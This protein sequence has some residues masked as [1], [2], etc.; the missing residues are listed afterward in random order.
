M[1]VV[2][3]SRKQEILVYHL[4]LCLKNIICLSVYL[5][6]LIL[7]NIF[8]LAL[9]HQCRTECRF[10]KL[11]DRELHRIDGSP[12][13]PLWSSVSWKILP[14][15]CFI[16][17]KLEHRGLGLK[18]NKRGQ[19]CTAQTAYFDRDASILIIQMVLTFYTQFTI[20]C[21]SG[22]TGKKKGKLWTGVGQKDQTRAAQTGHRHLDRAI[23][24]ETHQRKSGF[25]MK[26][27]HRD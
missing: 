15:P 17:L 20:C 6:W 26:K 4:L 14:P 19:I 9:K 8:G 27:P 23:S 24:F 25:C 16:S 12:D 2:T 3:E 7:H 18:K 10:K 22:K 21:S 5:V 11:W 1:I 13:E